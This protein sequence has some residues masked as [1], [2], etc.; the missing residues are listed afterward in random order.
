MSF[1]ER[2]RS[3]YLLGTSNKQLTGK[4]QITF[5]Q[6]GLHEAELRRYFEQFEVR[7]EIA[8]LERPVCIMLFTN[9]SGSSLVSEHLRATGSFTGLGEPL[10]YKLVKERCEE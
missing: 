9:R 4:M 1:I 7:G 2:L 5:D 6:V 8:P 10:N 3:K